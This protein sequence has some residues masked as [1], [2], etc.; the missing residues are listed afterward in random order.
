MYFSFSSGNLSTISSSTLSFSALEITLV[1]NFLNSLFPFSSSHF[2]SYLAISS[3]SFF[4][5]SRVIRSCIFCWH[6]SAFFNT[7]FQISSYFSF[8]SSSYLDR[9][10]FNRFAVSQST[11]SSPFFIFFSFSIPLS[12]SSFFSPFFLFS[13]LSFGI[14]LFPISSPLLF[15]SKILACFPPSSSF[16][17][18]C[19]CFSSSF[20]RLFSSFLF[21]FS[22]HVIGRRRSSSSVNSVDEISSMCQGNF[23]FIEV[24]LSEI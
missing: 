10:F 15:A 22:S 9:I 24:S 19:S 4:S 21:F 17:F 11:I 18:L 1:A 8:I 14:I 16:S 23:S 5:N 7:F 2:F 13:P 12:F 3:F 20:S 6:L